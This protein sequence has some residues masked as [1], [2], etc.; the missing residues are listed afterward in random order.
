M[1]THRPCRSAADSLTRAVA[2]RT[3]W[4]A[5]AHRASSTSRRCS[6]GSSPVLGTKRVP[7]MTEAEGLEVSPHSSCRAP[8]S[9]MS[10][11]GG[12]RLGRSSRMP[13]GSSCASACGLAPPQAGVLGAHERFCGSRNLGRRVRT[14]GD[15][16]V[17][18]S[19]ELV[20]ESTKSRLVAICT[21]AVGCWC[22]GVER[23]VPGGGGGVVC[24]WWGSGGP[25]A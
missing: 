14:F 15:E 23:L 12:T 11:A 20:T 22:S 21:A 25:G 17:L 7:R 18:L 1:G 6:H 16:F 19:T 2:E 9:W 3:V 4:S 24:V 8:G 10:R 13:P 5:A